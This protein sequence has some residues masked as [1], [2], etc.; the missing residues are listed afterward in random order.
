MVTALSSLLLAALGQR[1]MSD[2]R[3]HP[4]FG[5]T[6][7]STMRAEY[8]KGRADAKRKVNIDDLSDHYRKDLG[9]VRSPKGWMWRASSAVLLT[10]PFNWWDA[11][12]KDGRAYRDS[13]SFDATVARAAADPAAWASR[14]RTL[15]LSVI[16]NAWPGVNQNRTG[17]TYSAKESDVR[18][19]E[20][21][22]LVDGDPRQALHPILPE[23][24]STTVQTGEVAS[25]RPAT[26]LVSNAYGTSTVN[27]TVTDYRGYKGYTAKWRLAFPLY[28]ASGV[29]TVTARTKRLVLKV[30]RPVGELT[31]TFNLGD[32]KR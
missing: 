21:V 7:A 12:Y 19:V 2:D 1:G 32:Y 15:D 4:L 29:P 23:L 3:V 18:D 20:F 30:I 11:G 27:Y 8:A 10:E 24:R 31:T 16:L 14:I 26:A 17:F 25:S 22:I 13:A 28:S 5:A 9:K 6:P